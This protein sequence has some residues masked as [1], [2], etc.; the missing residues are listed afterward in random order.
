MAAEVNTGSAGSAGSAIKLVHYDRSHGYGAYPVKKFG[1]ENAKKVC[2]YHASY[3]EYS[4][5]LRIWQP[6]SA[7]LRSM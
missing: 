4:V 2:A 1:P 3:P 5:T 6:V 7:W